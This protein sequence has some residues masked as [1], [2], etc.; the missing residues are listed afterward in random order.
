MA[1]EGHI[2]SRIR[3]DCAPSG[4]F[5]GLPLNGRRIVFYEHAFYTL[6]GGK[7]AEVFSV[8]DKTGIEAQLT[9]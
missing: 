2:A 5:L 9:F 4:E 8:I 3:F 6:V 1:D 7:I